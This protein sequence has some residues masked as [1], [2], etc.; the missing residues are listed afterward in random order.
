M[1][2]RRFLIFEQL[3]SL[4]ELKRKENELKAQGALNESKVAEM[5]AEA[6]AKM[7]EHEA[8]VEEQ[9]NHRKS[10]MEARMKAKRI[11][12]KNALK[13][14]HEEVRIQATLWANVAVIIV[15]A[16]F[17]GAFL[18][19]CLLLNHSFSNKPKQDY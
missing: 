14:K 10:R 15:R 8:H 3:Q 11:K 2:L 9:A 19:Y 12:K 17:I 16:I 6:K 1:L 7:I 13:R 18:F 5:Q 4:E